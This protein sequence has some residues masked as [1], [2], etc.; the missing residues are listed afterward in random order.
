MSNKVPEDELRRIASEYRHIQG[1][2]EREGESGSWRRRQKAQLSD[3][4]TRFEHILGHWFRDEA[5]RAQWRE[6]LYR[7]APEP[8]P[9]HDVPRLYRGRSESGSVVDVFETPTGEW[10]YL[11]DGAV[12]ERRTAGKSTEATVRLGG[13]TFQEAFDTPAEVLQMLRTYVAEQ[14]SGGPPWESA[15]QLFADGL[16]DMNFSLTERGQRF[17]QS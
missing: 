3:L 2:H 10:E 15:S 8:A 14:P 1:E 4:E 5:T 16:I 11:V 6:H 13:Q 9:V 12:A 7:A 17:I